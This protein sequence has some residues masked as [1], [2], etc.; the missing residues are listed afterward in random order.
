MVSKEETDSPKLHTVLLEARLSNDLVAKEK[1]TMK[2][3]DD[4]FSVSTGK[5]IVKR[6]ND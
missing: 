4:Y 3:K 6:I 2:G 5:Q 1:G